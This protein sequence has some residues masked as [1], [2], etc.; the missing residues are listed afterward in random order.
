[1]K[2]M[3]LRVASCLLV[4]ALLWGA[5]G[6]GSGANS[7]DAKT[8]I[9]IEFDDS[10]SIFT[11]FMELRDIFPEYEF[12]LRATVRRGHIDPAR[13]VSP[14]TSM[15]RAR[16]LFI[17][18]SK[19]ND[20]ADIVVSDAF[21][22]DIPNLTNAFAE[23]SGNAYTSRIQTSYLN[24][25]AIGGRLYYL[26]FFIGLR[27]IVYNRTLFDEKGWAVP[28]NYAEFTQLLS[29]IYDSGM[30]PISVRT[31]LD[32]GTGLYSTAYMINEGTTMEG[33][34]WLTDFSKGNAQATREGTVETLKYL[35]MLGDLGHI[36]DNQLTLKQSVA[37][38]MKDREVAMCIANSEAL[39]QIY[40]SGT[41]D[42]FAMMPLYS[43]TCPDGII[44][45]HNTLH[46]GMSA[47]AAADP[48][49]AEALDRIM[50]YIYSETGQ[51]RMLDICRGLVSP[52][53]GL[54]YNLDSPSLA[55]FKK[56]LEGGNLIVSSV[57]F[58]VNKTFD[59]AMV[60]F[61]SG[62]GT[63]EADNALLQALYDARAAWL[64]LDKESN[65]V[66]TQATETFSVQQVLNFVMKAMQTQ[67][68]CDVAVTPELT[69]PDF[70]GHYH[71]T[72]L[73]H[74]KIYDGDITAPLLE[75]VL[76]RQYDVQV[77]TMTGAQLLALVDHNKTNNNCFGLTME[78]T[79]DKE[80]GFYRTTG[81]YLENGDRLDPNA[82]YRVCTSRNIFIPKSGYISA[83]PYEQT[84]IKTLVSY[85][86]SQESI[87]PF[88]LPEPI[89]IK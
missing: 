7:D 21:G 6:C 56:V 4:S 53:Y 32:F 41:H 23:V 60:A 16:A 62:D 39:S 57:P 54:M 8:K 26:P 42:K 38:L 83:V 65:Q 67:T 45:E 81:A 88:D 71:D 72:Q 28:T 9:V 50:D 66:L 82:E 79:L 18:A 78:L 76:V 64:S 89:I 85:C 40:N 33:Y 17:Q 51:K 52:C 15:E 44:I 77:Y 86:A 74:S 11:F 24:N 73:T 48:K 59:D 43:E 1:M 61:L 5:T 46:L 35:R 80:K 75:A 36:A 84:L 70:Y 63:E 3:L 19:H 27:G 12:E 58:D 68:G 47:K 14:F 10:S 13:D 29:T 37:Y 2:N 30:M 69:L 49:K 22:A 31:P 20:V 55:S 34:R 25:V 87:S